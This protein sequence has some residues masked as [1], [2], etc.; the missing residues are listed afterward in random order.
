MTGGESLHERAEDGVTQ[1][2]CEPGWTD[3]PTALAGDVRL[4]NDDALRPFGGG[5]YD[6][7]ARSERVILLPNHSRTDFARCLRYSPA[8]ALLSYGQGLRGHVAR[9]LLS[10]HARR[11]TPTGGHAPPTAVF[12]GPML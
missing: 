9:Q 10:R 5:Y 2:G 8:G 3:F 6:C 11:N 7:P 4:L 12:N 1:R